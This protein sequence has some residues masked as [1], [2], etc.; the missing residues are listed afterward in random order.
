MSIENIESNCDGD[1]MTPNVYQEFVDCW[2]TP[3]QREA[4]V[5]AY[6]N[7][8]TSFV[9][10]LL[11]EHLLQLSVQETAAILRA[12]FGSAIDMALSP[13]YTQTETLPTTV[14]QA[15]RSA[16]AAEPDCRWLQRCNMVGVN[17]RTLGNFWNL[18]KYALTLPQS[19]DA[20]QLLPIWEPGVVGSLYGMSSWEPNLEFFSAELAESCPHLATTETQLRAVV[21][22]LHVMGK[23]VG[24]DVVPHTDRFSQIVLSYPEYFEWLQ[25][26]D[27]EIISHD[28]HLFEAVQQKIMAFL[29]LHGAAVADEP[30]PTERTTFFSDKTDEARRLRILFGQPADA[31]LRQSRRNLLIQYL[32]SYGYEPMPATMAPPF[33]GMTPDRR[34]EAKGVDGNGMIWRDFMI[35]NPQP[36]SRVFGPLAR[37]KLYHPRNRN[38]DW[39]LDFDR[40]H[41]EA[42]DYV[43]AHYAD[44]QR[45][46]GLDF[47]RGDMAH[48]QMRPDG[49]PHKLD[50]YYDILGAIKQYIQEV[51][52]APSFGYFAETF[53]APRD[54]F[55]YGEEMDHLEAADADASLGDLQS[56]CVGS[57]VFL[58]RF[59]QYADWAETRR[60]T[61]SFTL[62]TG[63][64]DDP[65][66]DEFYRHGSDVRLFIALFLTD[67]PSY[68]GAGFETR[69]IH[70]APAPNEHY[71]KL[72]VFHEN[73]GPKATHGPYLWGK[74]GVLFSRLTRL[75]TYAER[76]WTTIR[77]AKCRWLIPPDANGE[78]PIIAWT[79]QTTPQYLFVVNTS[80]D[81]TIGRMG[82]PLIPHAAQTIDLLLE[83]STLDAP[84]AEDARIASNGKHYQLSSLLPG[85]G[86][87]YRVSSPV[88]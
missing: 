21:N 33:R 53:L 55:G 66:F 40:P 52:N 34:E 83:F 58:Q 30:I 81:R 56:T 76:I 32:F 45:R 57:P 69:D 17:V 24:M 19:H 16:A 31:E 37:Y 70:Y 63:D 11:P 42:W 27:A 7:G 49:V 14:P 54:V 61:P 78:N 20:I 8:K 15:I 77:G 9:A 73:D 28:E 79:P 59:R 1:P 50:R 4:H 64:K 87:V 62:M 10:S 80:P 85:E 13:E 47:M 75:R 5:Q 23:T 71:T 60:C 35:T 67:M 84:N 29:A 51:N 65:R 46:Y 88:E 36:M 48:V 25:R 39:E 22:L 72:F 2:Q 74:N 12:R 43:C 18:V 26:Q 82:I 38:R 3:H 6:I 44:V 86:R 68:M 41:V